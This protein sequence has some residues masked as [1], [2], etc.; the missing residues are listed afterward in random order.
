MGRK[1]IDQ[2]HGKTGRVFVSGNEVCVISWNITVTKEETETTNSCSAGNDEFEY[3][4]EV[5]T[6][7][8]EAIWDITT[9]P[10]SDAPQ[11]INGDAYTLKLYINATAGIG[12][13]D[14]PFWLILAKINGIS[15][16]VQAKQKVMYSFN[17]KSSGPG[18]I[19]YPSGG[20]SA[21]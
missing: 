11:L 12:L 14:G 16:G 18:S 3:G 7:T 4:S 9:N 2:A 8:I 21:S 17:Y 10:F 15:M 20:D 6:G 13:A 1:V 19:T 5:A